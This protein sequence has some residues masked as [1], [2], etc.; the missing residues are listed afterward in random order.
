M[1]LASVVFDSDLGANVYARLHRVWEHSAGKYCPES[2]VDT[3]RIDAPAA[4][5]R[6][7]YF[8]ESNHA[9]LLKWV[10]YCEEHDDDIVLMD[11]D[12]VVL[13]D[14]RKVFTEHRFDVAVTVRRMHVINGGVVYVRKG[15]RGREILRKWYDADT[16]L[17]ADPRLHE[18]YRKQ[19]SGMNQS[20]YGFM[21]TKGAPSGLI[22][23]PCAQYN[24]VDWHAG[25]GKT[26][27][28]LHVKSALRQ[29]CLNDRPANGFYA[30]YVNVW[31]K[32]EAECKSSV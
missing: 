4:P 12:T 7:R 30:R 8:H 19:Y 22:E 14:L 28:V 26:P 20:S 24:M 3:I 21:I 31:R 16:I 27:Y 10:E 6:D 29:R 15:Q 5:D 2:A 32:L 23:I 25:H 1:R 9:K 11:C 13:R 18:Q 17:H